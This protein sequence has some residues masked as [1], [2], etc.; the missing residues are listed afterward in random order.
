MRLPV[1]D[2]PHVLMTAD[3]LGGVWQYSL[4]L[5]EGLVRRGLRVTVA[6]LG[7]APGPERIAAAEA[8]TGCRI[9][10]T[11][12]ALDWMAK[13]PAEVRAAGA[14][15]ARLATSLHADIVHLHAPALAGAEYPV[16]V[17]AVCHS[18]VGTWWEALETG[19][20]PADLA[21]RRDLAAEGCARVDALLAPT[22][23]F[24]AATQAVYGLA[25]RPVVVRNG[26]RA[27]APPADPA[28]PAP[29][30]FTAG[31]LW[32]RAKNAAALDRVAARLD[33]PLRAAGPMAGPG[34]E[35]VR[36]PHLDG[37]GR[38]DDR[39]IAAHLGRRP[40]FLSL[41][42]YEPFGLAVLEAA[43]AGCALV[44]SDLASFRELWDGAALFVDPEDAD[45]AVAAIR[46]LA[47]D[48]AERAR[49]GGAAQ[50]RAGRYGVEAM[51]GGVLGIFR[52]C[53]AG[54]SVRSL[55]GA[56]A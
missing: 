15:L 45:G 26:R 19:P 44:L 48:P 23:A 42:R 12:L 14:A 56:A 43:S 3:A 49:R 41:A 53:W 24:A 22:H 20:L 50:A 29:Y 47:D 11:G 2:H 51:T 34:N 4:D 25:A 33:W 32:D 28:P 36:A 38:L 10:A 46:T 18:C 54:T 37:L 30:V 35:R 7:P 1:R 5:G 31:R 39:G 9:V 27:P 40:V 16:P 8:A 52:A 21:W 17:V 6:I 55:G 13:G